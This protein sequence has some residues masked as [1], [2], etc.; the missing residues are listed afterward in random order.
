MSKKF[1]LW[2]NTM[3]LIIWTVDLVNHLNGIP[4]T[5]TAITCSFI[6]CITHFSERIARYFVEE[7][8]N[9]GTENGP[10]GSTDL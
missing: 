3:C 9:N 10:S 8:N 7:R 2:I 4:V 5:S 1:W 6:M